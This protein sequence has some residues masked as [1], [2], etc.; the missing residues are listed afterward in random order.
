MLRRTLAC[1][2]AVSA[3]FVTTGCGVTPD[4]A[5]AAP[6][7]ITGVHV[8][9][10][11]SGDLARDQTIV[12]RDGRIESIGPAATLAV[13]PGATVFDAAGAFAIPGLADMH[14]H[15]PRGDQAEDVP[16]ERYFDLLLAAG[17]TTVRSMRG[18][19]G[20]TALRDAIARGD[21]PGPRLIAASP[22]ING[23][24]APD[25]ATARAL[26]QRFAREGYDL[27]KITEG[28]D[29][30]TFD[31][32]VDEARARGRRLAGHVPDCVEVA[33][34]LPGYWTLEH[35]HGH[36][37]V[38]ARDPEALP[39]LV[40]DT[41]AHGVKVCPT[42]GFQVSWYGQASLA[43]LEAWPGVEHAPL[44][45]L[46]EWRDHAAKQLALTRRSTAKNRHRMEAN[47]AAVRALDAA[48]ADLLVSASGGWFLVPGFSMFVEMR[49]LAHA[50]LTPTRILRAATKDAARAMGQADQWGT[51]QPSRI[52]DI[53]L[54]AADPRADI[55]N[56]EQIVAVVRRGILHDRAELDRRLAQSR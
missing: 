47:Y 11:G 56:V 53:V 19:P 34:T 40:R 20:D 3:A 22:V 25:P 36:G 14:V 29:R 52:A 23:A 1:S 51:I 50:G 32:I 55:T 38:S 4:H 9:D 5:A 37:S 49:Q 18:A 35:L 8:V 45:A 12:V 26:V 6:L 54:V 30:P 41:V 17:V 43:E 28:M 15:L 27:L 7:A 16:L 10:V 2:L 48:G 33:D 42:L 13:P 31:A 46:A 24:N 21:R 39:A 44:A